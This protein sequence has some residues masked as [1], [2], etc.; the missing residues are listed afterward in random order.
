M[1]GERGIVL[2]LFNLKL[3]AQLDI[4]FIYLIWT[5]VSVVYSVFVL[6]CDMTLYCSV[7]LFFFRILYCSLFLYCAVS[8][9]DV[10]VAAL[11]VLFPCFFLSC[12]ANA[13]VQ[14]AKTEHGSHFPN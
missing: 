11:T 9:C 7:L 10:R 3:F 14:L 5:G 13:R 2:C 1:F 12:K 4:W 6:F 8:A